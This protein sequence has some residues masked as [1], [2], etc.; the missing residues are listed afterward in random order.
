MNP[1]LEADI[2]A[3]RRAASG[4]AATGARVTAAAADEPAP[5]QVP[6]WATVD[7]AQLA[8]DAARRQ[9]T[10]IGAEIEET[11]RRI[12]AAAEAYELADARAAT[13]LRLTR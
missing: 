4:V 13:R 2:E 3:L 5:P 10:M 9:L 1:D 8:A 6:R 12:T 7:A 11:A